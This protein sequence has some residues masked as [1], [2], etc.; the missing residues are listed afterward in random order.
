M[1]RSERNGDGDWRSAGTVLVT[2]ATGY[3]GSHLA[4]ELLSRGARVRALVRTPSRA[5]ELAEAGVELIE[6]DLKSTESLAR[7]IEGTSI[8]FNVAALFREAK[9]PDSEY[10]A[11]NADAPRKIVELAA[12]SR[13]RR[14][15]H[16]STIGVHGGVNGRPADEDAPFEPGDIY[17]TTKLAGELAAREESERLGVPL[18]VVRPASI[19]G[20]GDRRMLKLFAGVAHRRFPMI[21]SGKV[22]FHPVYIDDLV[23]GM[24]LAATREEAI[25]RT[26][27]LGGN[28]SVSLNEMVRTIAELA[29]V[30]PPRVHIPVGP[31]L[32][33]AALC[34]AVCVPLRIEPPLYRRRVAFFTK[35]RNFD[36]SRARR[37]LGYTPRFSWREGAER[38]F[39][40]YRAAGWL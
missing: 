20:P 35:S 34:E 13:V 11:V 12:D 39:T 16:C 9:F 23:D 40:W 31:V 10:V 8:I 37:E 14:V 25:G 6:G 28:S 1:A 19:Y 21:G 3:T 32:L 5:S 29:G 33:T 30:P 15:I 26:Y 2:G 17:Q 38:T 18:A 4:R 27:I 24:L 7:A 22:L 36:I